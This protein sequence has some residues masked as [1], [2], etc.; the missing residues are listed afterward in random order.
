M[1]S[2]KVQ[3]VHASISNKEFVLNTDVIDY[4]YYFFQ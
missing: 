2:L 3:T 4:N 1:M